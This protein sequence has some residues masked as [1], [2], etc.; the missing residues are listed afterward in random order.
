M[1]KKSG[2]LTNVI[3]ILVFLVGLSLILY[4]SVS[5]KWNTYHQTQA[6]LGY[7][8]VVRE[9][10]AEL[11]EA[12]FSRA[13]EYNRIIA[14]NGITWILNEEQK[15]KYNSILDV[16]GSGNMGY[17]EIPKLK[18]ML[19]VYH[20]VDENILQS[21][22]GHIEGSS[23]PVGGSGTHCIVSGHRG[24]PSAR[25]FTDLDKLI[26][27]DNFMLNVLGETLTYEVDEIHIVE[28]TDFTNLT[29]Q[30]SQD[31]VTLVTCT[32]YGINTHRLLVRGH[33]VENLRQGASVT[34]EA[35]KI[36]PLIVAPVLAIPVLAG[37][38][39]LILTGPVKKKN[40]NNE[41]R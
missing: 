17:L 31:L 1:K 20:S 37:W 9:M 15:K 2:R 14:E 33:R 4:P 6:V 5:N 28:P 10:D 23:M 30:D 13:R 27:G 29:V 39:I 12:M 7:D 32:P 11:R 40:D 35:V 34:S 26:P 19:P 8:R 21:A 24:L 16:N 25:L 38:I 36:D 41:S 22:I 18:L 3:L